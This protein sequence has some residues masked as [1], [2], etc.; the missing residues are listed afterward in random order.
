MSSETEFYI[1]KRPN[2]IC[3]IV[4]G[5]EVQNQPDQ[6]ILKQWGPFNSLNQAKAS[7]VGLIRS[8]KCQ[9]Q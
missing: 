6:T 8:G 2:G 1:V 7:R 5:E 9:P 3:D 4:L